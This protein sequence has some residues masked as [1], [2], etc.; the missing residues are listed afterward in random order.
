MAFFSKLRER[1]GRS[2]TKISSDLDDI[3]A[4]APPEAAP[5]VAPAPAPVEHVVEPPAPT[6][7]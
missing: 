1:L 5:E 4:E 3:V 6:A 2:S 7:A